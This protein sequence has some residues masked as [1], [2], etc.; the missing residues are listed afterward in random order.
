[1]DPDEAIVLRDIGR[2]VVTLVTCY[3]FHYF[4]PAPKRYIVHASFVGD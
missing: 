4:G 3:P 1:V 2:P